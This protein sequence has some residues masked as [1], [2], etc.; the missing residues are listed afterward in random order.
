MNNGSLKNVCLSLFG[1]RIVGPDRYYIQAFVQSTTTIEKAHNSHWRDMAFF[2]RVCV[3]SQA[4]FVSND[5]SLG[6][7]EARLPAVFAVAWE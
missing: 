1:R 3:F 4:H 6:E 2:R 7:G 5:D